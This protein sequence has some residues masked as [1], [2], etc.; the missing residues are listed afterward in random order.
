MMVM[1]SNQPRPKFS[2]CR[3]PMGK[4]EDPGDEVGLISSVPRG[5]TATYR[6]YRYVPL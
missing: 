5:G 1:N 2:A 3:C 4:R 6:L